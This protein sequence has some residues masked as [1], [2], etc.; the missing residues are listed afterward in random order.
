MKD[1]ISTFILSAIVIIASF[2]LQVH[3]SESSIQAEHKAEKIKVTAKE[4]VKIEKTAYQAWGLSI[5]EW[6]YYQSL[7]KGPS[8]KWY[9]KLDPIE[10]LGINARNSSEQKKY[11]QLVVK[12]THDRVERELAF[13]RAIDDAWKQLYPELKPIK[14]IKVLNPNE[15]SN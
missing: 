12:R 4:S 7:M 13:Q 11:A 5:E 2:F 9:K 10:V 1:C 14:N 15:K 6:K 3:A 8:K